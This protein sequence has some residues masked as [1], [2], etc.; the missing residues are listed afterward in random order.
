MLSFETPTSHWSTSGMHNTGR[1]GYDDASTGSFNSM[2]SSEQL[3]SSMVS[4]TAPQPRI[5][6]A[7]S[8]HAADATGVGYA[9]HILIYF[10]IYNINN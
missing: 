1:T 9:N 8:F 6:H 5:P 3:P 10:N 2:Q 4:W 7:E